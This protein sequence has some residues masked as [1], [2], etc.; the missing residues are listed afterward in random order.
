[1]FLV[2]LSKTQ[3]KLIKRVARRQLDSLKSIRDNTTGFD[4]LDITKYCKANGLEDESEMRELIELEID[5]WEKVLK[6]PSRVGKLDPDS[7]MV[8]HTLLFRYYDQPG[9]HRK[10]R[11]RL[12]RKLNQLK[13]YSFIHN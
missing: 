7:I 12:L 8:L 10:A 6:R 1:M 5:S 13:F 9:A 4:E 2:P 11:S 3:K